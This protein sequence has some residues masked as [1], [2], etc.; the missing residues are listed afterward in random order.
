VLA[1][2]YGEAL[3]WHENTNV[4]LERTVAERTE[5]LRK[6]HDATRELVGN[7][8]H[9]LRTPMTAING[10]LE[11]LM[12]NDGIGGADRE[13]LE[14]AGIRVNQ[15]NKLISDLFL[16]SRIMEQKLNMAVGP[17]NTEEL[18]TICQ[19]QYH[20][21]TEQKGISLITQND[22]AGCAAAA[23]RDSLMRIM[24][25][26]MQNALYY[27]KSRIR[28]AAE[29]AGA[30]IIISVSDDGPGISEEIILHIFDRFYKGRKDGTGLGLFIVKELAAAMNGEVSVISDPGSACPEGVGESLDYRTVF[31]LKLPPG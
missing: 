21:M 1:H 15:M 14:S 11:L 23:D 25:N 12:E 29:K 6:S 17:L 20:S 24:D 2:D 26:L 5:E 22:A 13:Y 30:G 3:T 10:Y 8:S 9:D 31:T 28:I 27:A 7:I 16:L 4:L 19:N 18:L